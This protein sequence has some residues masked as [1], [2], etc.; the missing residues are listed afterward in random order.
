MTQTPTITAA[1]LACAAL[2][3]TV[4]GRAQETSAALD[5]PRWAYEF[6]AGVFEPDL[7]LFEVFYGD[8]SENL[9]AIAGSYRF[10]DWLELG[11]EYSYMRAKGVGILTSSQALG[12][13]VRYQLNPVHVFANFILQ[14]EPDQLVVPYA[15]IGL[16]IARYE[17]EVAQQSDSKGRTDSGYS[18]RLGVRFMLGARRRPMS[19]SGSPYQR[20]FIFLEAQDLSFEA[21]SIELGGRAYSLGFR[22]EF[23]FQ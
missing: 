19:M 17:Q 5:S 2:A 13:S 22:M 21:D 4:T 12:G 3:F 6:R 7:N 20:S 11:G 18:T 8:D 10:K 16:A 15:G 9:Y 14:R 1:L 23:D